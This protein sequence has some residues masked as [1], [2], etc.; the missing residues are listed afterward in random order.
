MAGGGLRTEQPVRRQLQRLRRRHEVAQRRGQRGAQPGRGDGGDVA[1][2][3][4]RGDGAP[5]EQPIAELRPVPALRGFLL[6]Q[7]V[8]RAQG[9]RA[10]ARGA[11]QVHED[12]GRL[13]RVGGVGDTAEQPD[14]LVLLAK[15]LLHELPRRAGVGRRRHPPGRGDRQPRPDSPDPCS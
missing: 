14:E 7:A 9:V 3:G 1:R 5:A 13:A 8:E 15:E 12:G 6:Q 10:V 2:A 11:R 4:Q